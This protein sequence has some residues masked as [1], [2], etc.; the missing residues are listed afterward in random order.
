ML[1][2]PHLLEYLAFFWVELKVGSSEPLEHLPE[3]VKLFPER[4]ADD[5]VIIQL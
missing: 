3:V 2:L 1:R 5:D 4:P